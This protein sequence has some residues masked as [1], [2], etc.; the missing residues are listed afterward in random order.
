MYYFLIKLYHKY[1][2]KS[3]LLCYTI[4]IKG[5]KYNRKD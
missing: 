4:S 2:D 5:G 1:I 3:T